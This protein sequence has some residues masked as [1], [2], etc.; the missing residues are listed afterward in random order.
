MVSIK[1][2]NRG[3]L[4]HRMPSAG[5]YAEGQGVPEDEAE[6]VKWYRK[7]ADQG[8]ADCAIQVGAVL[9]KW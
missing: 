5:R 9:R 8:D 1:R 7:A 3:L 2:L 4:R 6:A